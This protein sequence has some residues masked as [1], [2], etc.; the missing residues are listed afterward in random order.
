MFARLFTRFIADD[1]S[2]S[3]YF[4]C[5]VATLIVGDAAAIYIYEAFE[6]LKV[7]FRLIR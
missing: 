6:L 2:A 7:G 5:A 4:M 3:Y 1:S